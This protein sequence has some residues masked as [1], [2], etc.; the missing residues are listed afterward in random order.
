MQCT[1]KPIRVFTFIVMVLI[2]LFTT[3][4]DNVFCIVFSD[5]WESCCV[6]FNPKCNLYANSSKLLWISDLG[7]MYQELDVR[8]RSRSSVPGPGGSPCTAPVAQH[9]ITLI[10]F[11]GTSCMAEAKW[12]FRFCFIKSIKC[13]FFLNRHL[14]FKDRHYVAMSSQNV[15]GLL[16]VPAE[17]CN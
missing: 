4:L 10:I 6:Q 2:G 15:F 1:H 5:E 8:S 9:P 7:L 13:P 11:W 12:G 14:C 17:F 3:P 16:A